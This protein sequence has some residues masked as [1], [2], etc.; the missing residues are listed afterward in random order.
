ML[1]ATLQAGG[2]TEARAGGVMAVLDAALHWPG[3]PD[4]PG[5]PGPTTA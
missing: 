3:Q 2:P 4:E 1:I 5:R